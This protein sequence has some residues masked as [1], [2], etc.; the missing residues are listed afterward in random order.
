MNHRTKAFVAALAI[1]ATLAF[2]RGV[3]FAEAS[4]VPFVIPPDGQG[5]KL[6]GEL[7]YDAPTAMAFDSISRPYMIEMWRPE[8][9]GQVVTIRK[10]QWVK[11]S[12]LPAIMEAYPDFKPT[13][14]PLPHARG[15]ITIDDADHI[16]IVFPIGRGSDRQNVLL[17]SQ[18]FAKSW[19]LYKLPPGRVSLEV[20]TGHNDMSA[21]PAVGLLRVTKEV[22]G[23]W[24]GHSTLSVYLPT[25][26][27]VGLDLGEPIIVSKNALTGSSGGHSGGGS[28]AVTRGN[29]THVV[30]SEMPAEGK[31]GN[32]VFIATIDRKARAIAA[33]EFLVTAG[34]R[35][36]DGHSRPVIAADRDGYLHVI[37]GS[38]NTAFQ[39]T[40]SLKPND[41]TAG[42]A[43][44][45]P[46]ADGQTYCSLVCDTRNRLHSA[47]RQWQPHATLCY[48][49]RFDH[50]SEPKTLVHGANTREKWMYGVFY[51]RMFIDRDGAL[52]ISFTF[53]ENITQ[54]EGDY[55]RAL[56]VSV[57]GGESWQLADRERFARRVFKKP[58]WKYRP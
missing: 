58:L 34:P 35:K 57:D 55:P 50:W 44:P 28:F 51:H 46:M 56:I 20:E 25:K 12:F 19:K 4:G 15:M 17:Y 31:N 48:Q 24:G 26:T 6:I 14:S 32:P 33:T 54:G 13:K 8:L 21:P 37:S 38:H 16:Y 7:D 3:C 18:D 30:Y 47:F 53:Y 10:G 40:H 5:E 11:R 27:D 43:A 39:Y 41:I 23:T 49:R 22:R 29:N 2:A 45:A 52:Y 1:I 36:A 9:F 42:W